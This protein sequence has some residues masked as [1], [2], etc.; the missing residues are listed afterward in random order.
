MP[1][2]WRCC[3][4]RW[5]GW[6]AGEGRSPVAAA[7]VVLSVLWMWRSQAGLAIFATLL[8]VAYA[9]GCGGTLAAG[10]AGGIGRGRAG[11]LIP[12][13]NPRTIAKSF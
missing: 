5:Q 4:W 9:A 6:Q 2:S 8:L 12:L 1:L 13:V 7:V 3:P 11:G 10:C